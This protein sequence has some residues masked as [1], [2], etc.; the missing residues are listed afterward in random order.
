MSKIPSFIDLTNSEDHA[1]IYNFCNWK[2]CTNED[3][4]VT[5]INDS[6]KQNSSSK[7]EVFSENVA[8]EICDVIDLTKSD[9]M[10]KFTISVTGKCVQ[11]KTTKLL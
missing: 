8:P 6:K 11:M 3:K 10:P 1:E 5:I 7:N 4:K 2:I 9:I